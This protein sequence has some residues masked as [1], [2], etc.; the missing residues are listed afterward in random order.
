MLQGIHSIAETQYL[1]TLYLNFPQLTDNF[2]IIYV[3]VNP[4]IMV[5]TVLLQE[6]IRF[7]V[8]FIVLLSILCINPNFII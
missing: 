7:Y 6:Q 8:R 1:K 2:C 4:W 3:T 5:G